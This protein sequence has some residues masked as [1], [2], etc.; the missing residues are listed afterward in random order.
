M[1][2]WTVQRGL[3]VMVLVVSAA[4]RALFLVLLRLR[5]WLGLRV[6]LLGLLRRARLCLRLRLRMELLTR[7]LLWLRMEFLTR[8]L[9]RLRLRMKLLTRLLLRLRVEF[10]PGLLLRLWL[11][12]KLRA[13]LSLWLW[14]RLRMHLGSRLL[15]GLRLR[16]HLG[17]RL[18][19]LHRRGRLLRAWIGPVRGLSL[20]GSAAKTIRRSLHGR[21]LLLGD[22]SR[23]LSRAG[24]LRIAALLRHRRMVLRPHRFA[25]LTCCRFRPL[26]AAGLSLLLRRAVHR[27]P[28][29]EL[30]RTRHAIACLHRHAV[31]LTVV[32]RPAA[33][34]SRLS[35]RRTGDLPW[36]E[37]VS[38]HPRLPPIH[39]RH[40]AA[41][42][43]S[44]RTSR[45]LSRRM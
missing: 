40:C 1:R 13:R 2:R 33:A 16:S 19:L 35:A 38:L 27:M 44:I 8:L 43:L 11:R 30:R 36:R 21:M 14:L 3:S 32:L 26:R 25:L 23:R 4:R 34:R 17:M 9:L 42:P 12:M 6:R 37:A 28:A 31:L 15:L 24:L 20:S 41:R 29:R 10:L 7:L 5:L 39:L 18:R 45:H 22:L